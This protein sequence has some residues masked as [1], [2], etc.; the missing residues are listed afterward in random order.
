MDKEAKDK[1][2]MNKVQER[3]KILKDKLMLVIEYKKPKYRTFY[4]FKYIKYINPYHNITKSDGSIAKQIDIMPN[5]YRR[6]AYTDIHEDEL[7]KMINPKYIKNSIK[8]I[9]I[10]GHLKLVKNEMWNIYTIDN[11]TM[12]YTDKFLID[13]KKIADVEIIPDT[14]DNLEEDIL[15]E[16]NS[17]SD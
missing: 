13:Y 6:I 2:A 9:N 1:E 15:V 11:L 14:Y 16:Y 7:Y 8:F 10:E 17:D 5:I 4:S 12:I 3:F